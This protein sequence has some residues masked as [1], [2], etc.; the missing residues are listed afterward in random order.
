[1]SLGLHVL[2]AAAVVALPSVVATSAVLAVVAP[3]AHQVRY[4]HIAPMVD[5]SATPLRPAV[6]SDR[7]RRSSTRERAPKPENEMPLLRGDTP[8]KVEGPGGER[9]IAADPPAPVTGP[10]AD[11]ALAPPATAGATPPVTLPIAP[12]GQQTAVAPEAS[13]LAQS[14]RNLRNY[15]RSQNR[16]SPLFDNAQGGATDQ[17][18]DIQFDS[19]GVDFGPWLRRFRAQV[20]R[21]WF[22]PQAAYLHQG[23]VV[24]QFNVHRDGR[25][26]DLVVA[27]PAAIG[28]LTSAAFN[29]IQ[30][31]SPTMALP[32]EYPGDVVFFT[33]TFKYL[34]R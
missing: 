18:A 5:R 2:A 29:A 15:F 17:G 21:N 7:D 28:A 26:T 19:K 13:G 23:R 11:P 14:L 25:I 32:A 27:Q 4:V 6:D 1:L 3:P 12:D 34:D 10:P 31:S 9:P 8:E 30:M 33:V 22:I 20:Y 16:S 24:L